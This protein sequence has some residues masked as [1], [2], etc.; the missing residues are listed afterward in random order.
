MLDKKITWLENVLVDY[1]CKPN[2]SV[3]VFKLLHHFLE[4]PKAFIPW[5]FPLS[6]LGSHRVEGKHK[7]VTAGGGNTLFYFPP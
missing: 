4:N 5:H 2:I 6:V 7:R 1:L 3:C